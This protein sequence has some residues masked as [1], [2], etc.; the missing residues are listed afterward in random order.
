MFENNKDFYPTPKK[1]INKMLEAIDFKTVSNILEPSAGKGD[2]VEGIKNKIKSI[3]SNNYFAREANWD[4]DCIEIDEDLRH[5]LTGKGLRIIHDDFL[6]YN[7]F[8]KYDLIIANF[9]F[10]QGDKHLLKALELIEN[11]G[12][13]VCLINAETIKNPYS[14]LRKTLIKKLNKYNANIE[15]LQDEFVNAERKTEVEIALI[16]VKIE[17]KNKDSIILEKLKQEEEF[18]Q[19]TKQNND[20]LID[21]DFLTGIVQQYNFE[22]KAGIKLINEYKN[23][24]SIMLKSFKDDFDKN[25]SILK[26]DINTSKNNYYTEKTKNNLINEYIENV[27][28]KYWET[29]FNNEKFTSLLTSNLLYEFRQKLNDLKNYDFSL[30]NIRELQE[31]MNQNVIKRVEDTILNL[32]EEFSSQYSWYKEC[33]KNIH[34]YNGWSS[35]SAFKIN[36]HIII[37]L[38]SYGILGDRLDYGYKFYEKLKDI[39]HVF[40]YLDGGK[41][42]NTNLKEILDEAEKERQTKNIKTKYF[43]INT[44]KKGTTH[45]TFLNEELL[46][47]FNIFGSCKK[48][49]LPFSYGK[50][51]Y[52]D[53][54]EKEKQ[55]IDEFE[56]KESYEKTMRNIDYYIYKPNQI[57]MLQ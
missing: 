40:D 30:Y 35:N 50:C 27:R 6:T 43:S 4:I 10:S 7:G 9:P 33:S 52:E 31:Q 48:G 26:L 15:Y 57:L 54:S 22:I 16:Q 19:E 32:F 20:S 45:L 11:G 12:N 24:Q 42:E 55:V 8:K 21:G 37:P 41:T 47:K 25:R 38:S 28:Y 39:E 3:K 23:L 34:Y 18:N 13:L 36:K 51:K 14:N 17:N 1:L 5:I 53:M 49:W 44:Y 56:G 29:L 2:I 46:K